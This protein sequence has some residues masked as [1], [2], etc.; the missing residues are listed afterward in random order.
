MTAIHELTSITQL[1]KAYRTWFLDI[2]GVLHNGVRPYA[3]AVDACHRFRAR[4]GRVILVSNSPRPRE[5]VCRQLDQIGVPRDA[6]DRVLTS[7][8]VSRALIGAHKGET[9]FHLGPQRDLPVY[10]GLDVRLGEPGDAR[11]V[12]CTG[13]FDDESET[14]EDYR[15]CLAMCQARDLEMICVNPDIKV[16]RGGRMVYCAGAL[17]QAYEEIGGKVLYA[18]KPHAPIY[19]AALQMARDLCGGAIA[20]PDILAIGDGAKTDIAG[21]IAAGIDAV[22]VA[23]KVSMEQGETLAEAMERL[24]AGAGTRPVGVMRAL[25][26]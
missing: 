5:G 18:G 21:A 16:E 25:A 9:V 12:V 14:P 6:Y 4:G 10:Q 7:G 15:D 20:A 24:F 23:S 2:W 3:G 13:L 1:S 17:A 8:D 22:Y 19:D 26:W 11:A